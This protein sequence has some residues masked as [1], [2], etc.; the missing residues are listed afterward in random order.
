MYWTVT[1]HSSLVDAV[2]TV[3]IC[4]INYEDYIVDL[5]ILSLRMLSVASRT[6]YTTTKSAKYS[7]NFR[8]H[9]PI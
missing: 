8:V 2:W 9:F 3:K 4:N 6:K 5:L 7:L 1:K